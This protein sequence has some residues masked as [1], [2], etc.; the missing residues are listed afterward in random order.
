MRRGRLASPPPGP[1]PTRCSTR[2]TCSTR[3]GPRRRRTRC[4]GSSVCSC[5]GLRRRR[6]L[7]AG[8]VDAHRVRGRPRRDPRSRVRVRCLQ[9]QRRT[10]SATADRRSGLRPRQVSST[11]TATLRALGRGG[12]TRGRPRATR[13]APLAARQRT[14]TVVRPPATRRGAARPPTASVVGRVVRRCE[15]VDGSV[16]VA[17]GPTDA[18]ALLTVTIVRS[19]TPP[20]G[21][22]PTRR[23]RRRD[24][25]LARRRAHAARDRRRRFVSVLDPADDAERGRRRVHQRGHVPRARRQ[26]RAHDV[27]LV[28]ADHPLR[29]PRRSRPRA[30]VTSSTQPRS[31]RSS[32]AGADLDRRREGRGTRHRSRRPRSST[33]A[34]TW[35]P[36]CGRACTGRSARSRPGQSTAPTTTR[37]CRG[38]T[39]A[40]DA[41]GRPVRPTRLL[42]GGV[43]V[44]TGTSVRLH[45]SRR[46]DAHDMFFAGRMATVGRVFHDVDG[47]MHVAVTVDDDPATE[48]LLVA[49]AVSCTSIPTRSSARG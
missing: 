27:M 36:R 5:P 49:R 3:T 16:R 21:P 24:A 23:A 2:A 38:G 4:A 15:P 8:G 46:A 29:P 13:P 28:L 35:R 9:V 22:N 20:S 17:N 26:R 31:T 19:R 43:E 33:A 32:P 40:V 48:A 47:E 11:S 30:P 44:G 7:G 37:P 1:W 42:V 25:P 14:I 12:G 45:P 41:A 18:D 6:R 34:T 10:S 39:R